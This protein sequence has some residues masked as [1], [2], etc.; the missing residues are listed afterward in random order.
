MASIEVESF[1]YDL[2]HCKDKILESFN[3]WDEKY[4]DDERGALVA[5]IR[6]CPDSRLIPFLMNVQKL[7]AGYER[8][9]EM[10]Q[11]AEQ[12][13]VDAELEEEDDEDDD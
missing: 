13:E 4:N 11:A 8:I 12:A 5:G 2:F 3:E 9:Q 10:I 1:F 7:A 6:E